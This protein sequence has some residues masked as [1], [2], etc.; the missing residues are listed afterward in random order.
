[1]QLLCAHRS[2]GHAPL[3]RY[4]GNVFFQLVERLLVEVGDV[5]TRVVEELDEQTPQ[6]LFLVDER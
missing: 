3:Q 6:V 5:C 2:N 4:V 1:M